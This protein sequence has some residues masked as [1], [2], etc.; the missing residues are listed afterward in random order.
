MCQ[1]D[2]TLKNGKTLGKVY[3]PSHQL[4]TTN[5]RTLQQ[6]HCLAMGPRPERSIDLS[7]K[8]SCKLPF[9]LSMTASYHSRSLWLSGTHENLSRCIIMWRA[10]EQFS[11][12]KKTRHKNCSP[13]L[14]ATWATPIATCSDRERSLCNQLVMWKV[15][16][17]HSWEGDHQWDI[18]QTACFPPLK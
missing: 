5:E 18:P 8:G 17:L 13:M 10:W 6:E 2:A 11:Y 15:F 1:S 4:N 7:A 16:R 9:S 12:R 14:C 3:M